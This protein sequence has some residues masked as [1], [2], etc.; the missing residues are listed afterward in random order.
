ML[1]LQSVTKRFGPT[2]ALDDASLTVAPGEFVA[3]LGPSGCGKTTALRVAAGFE[4]PDSGRV[5]IDGAAVA[6]NGEFVAPERRAVGMVFQDYALFPHLD[7]AANVGF[8]LPRR[9]RPERVREL[10]EV[11]GLDGLGR[12]S[13]GELSGGQQQRVALARALAPTPKLVLLD[14]P[15]SAIDALLREEMREEL[16]RVLREQGVT[17]VLVTHDREE[18]FTLA[19]RIALMREGRVVQCGTPEE[20]YFRPADRWAARFVGASNMVPA[21]LARHLGANG[22]DLPADADEVLLRPERI[23]L[24]LDPSGPAEVVHRT[25]LGHDVLY[26]VRLT[27]GTLLAAQR[28]SNEQVPLGSRVHVHLHKAPAPSFDPS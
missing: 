25:F 22:G 1:E 27:D 13:P 20:L 28:P 10:L 12:R 23:G 16:A 3:L 2:T 18:A 14:E 9:D 24:E 15:W 21:D 19:D 8:G 6:H 17:V 26:R 5:E 7:V 4:R 11:V